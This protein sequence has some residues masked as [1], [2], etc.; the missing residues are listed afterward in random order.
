MNACLSLGL[1]GAGTNNARLAQ[2]L[3][4]LAQYYYKEPNHLFIVRI[5]QGLLHMGKGLI[6]CKI[7]HSDRFLMSPVGLAG[8]LTTLMAMTE[9]KK[10]K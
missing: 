3:R 1:I 4:Q 5:A 10:R 7:Y 8:I 6:N 9:S 2:L